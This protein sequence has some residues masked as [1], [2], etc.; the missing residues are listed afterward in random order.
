[1]SHIKQNWESFKN[2][3]SEVCNSELAAILSFESSEFAT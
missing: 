1:M 2:M 3:Y